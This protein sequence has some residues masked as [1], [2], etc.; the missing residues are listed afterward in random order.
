MWSQDKGNGFGLKGYS[1]RSVIGEKKTCGDGEALEGVA[2][3]R[4]GF[5]FP[6]SPQGQVGWGSK[7][8]DLM[9]GAL[10]HSR[11]LK[12]MILKVLCTSKNSVV[13]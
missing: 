7:Q 3:R 4:C 5:P 2:Q 9:E 10:A 1:T 13:Q 6:G 12:Q 11:E 8:P